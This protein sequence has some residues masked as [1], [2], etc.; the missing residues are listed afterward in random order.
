MDMCERR[1]KIL[2]LFRGDNSDLCGLWL[3]NPHPDVVRICCEYF[4]VSDF[5]GVRVRLGD[6]CRWVMGEDYY[7]H[8]QGKTL[9]ELFL[10]DVMGGRKRPLAYC[11]SV[12]DVEHYPWPNLDYLDFKKMKHSL[13]DK[14]RYVRFGGM[15]SPF[16]HLVSDLFGM[17]QYF[18]N[19]Y[20]NPKIVEAVTEHV[21]DFYLEANRLCF[22]EC[23]GEIDVFFF[24][25]DFGTQLD[26]LI[27]PEMFK[28][29]VLPYLRKLV[30]LAKSYSLP[31]MLHSCGSIVKVI[32]DLI[33]IGIDA[34]HPLQAQAR[35]MD[36]E[37]LAR[38]FK[39]KLTFVGGVDTQNL[40]I[41]GST[42]DIRR[43]VYYLRRTFGER[44]IVSP[45]HEAILP[46][47]PPQNIEA[48]AK[49]T[50]DPL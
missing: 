27:S 32:P 43:E 13:I 31:V 3:G 5:E 22:E 28:K 8:P 36:A 47:V 29:F 34:L 48:M 6:D 18:I 11:E 44:Y 16:F 21:V 37:T 26:L 35:G 49:A 1:E 10:G 23:S 38:Q 42:D 33:D 41:N 4:G 19:M 24:G 45:S 39:G 20:C 12:E 40:L 17:E 50:F 14:R 9:F 25:N 30:G 46:N 7:K 15:W 2:K